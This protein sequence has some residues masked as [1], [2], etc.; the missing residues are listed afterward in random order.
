MKK[1]FLPLILLCIHNVH[2]QNCS[3]T[4]VGFPP[5]NDLGK[6][7]WRGFQGGLYP[8]G[9]NSR[10]PSHEQSGR[11]IA[12]RI[13]PLDSAGKVDKVR[14]KIVWL[15]IGLSHT[16]MES[17]VFISFTDTFSKKNPQLILVD[18]AQGGQDINIIDNP[19]ADYWNVVNQRLRSAG[20]TP[21]QVQVVW[22]KEA[23]KM[24]T[25]TAFATYP[26]ALK[27]KYKTAIQIL[28]SKFPNTRLCYL[29]SRSYAGY[30]TSDLNPEPYA[31]YSGWSVKRLIED[32][33]KG[34]T[35]LRF[36][37]SNPR[38]PWLA[39]GPYLWADGTTPR[40]DGLTWNCPVDYLNDGTHPSIIGRQKVAT[41]L[42]QFFST[43]STT[44]PWFIK[45]S[46]NVST[47]AAGVK[48]QGIAN[49]TVSIIPNPSKGE[50]K[51]DLK[52]IKP[53]D[54]NL[55]IYDDQKH[56]LISKKLSDKVTSFGENLKPGIYFAEIINNSILLN[57]IKIIKSE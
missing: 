53:L 17:R 5:I 45:P 34:D 29:A 40:S 14:G 24:P 18:G 23:E 9:S 21:K 39:W 2:A 56:L 51:I 4:S 48:T 37:G 13:M 8:N 50:F 32:Q 7:Y 28:K 44:V 36:N 6:G 20:L 12:S 30:A 16:T 15:S 54:I 33:I 47:T 41:L 19:N 46:N 52:E 42:L 27:L 25:D 43:D 31:F 38:A 57:R 11:N 3:N 49:N 26:D 1:I 10:P 35:S 55:N 22:F